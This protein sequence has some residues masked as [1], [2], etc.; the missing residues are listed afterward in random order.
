MFS[1]RFENPTSDKTNFLLE[2][3]DVLKRVPGSN[4][5]NMILRSLASS[6]LASLCLT[7]TLLLTLGNA[8]SLPQTVTLSYR[9]VSEPTGRPQALAT[10]SYDPAT[11]KTSLI[12]WTPPSIPPAAPKQQQQ[13]QSSPLLSIY[14]STNPS[15]TTITS[16]DS[17]SNTLNQTISLW[18]DSPFTAD[19]KTRIITSASIHAS[20]PPTAAQL[21][22]A[23]KLARRAARSAS[24]SSSATA[25]SKSSTAPT[26]SS[27]PLKASGNV[28]ITLHTPVTPAP[29]T[30]ID[31]KPVVVGADGQ[32]VP[33]EELVEKSFFQKY[34]WVFALGAILALQGGAGKE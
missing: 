3:F 21:K 13:P 17:L 23:A 1:A 31:R 18:L 9:S 22:E 26:A 24:K 25:K 29:P 11:L 15:S 5:T 2:V 8:Q 16:L 28:L 20:P 4:S 34:W 10:I 30:L 6:I 7:L 32:E 12:S 27:S 14:P 33:Q 19:G